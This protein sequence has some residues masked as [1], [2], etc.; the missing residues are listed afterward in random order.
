MSELPQQGDLE[1]DRYMNLSAKQENC[2][3]L[4]NASLVMSLWVFMNAPQQTCQMIRNQQQPS[5]YRMSHK[6]ESK[7]FCKTLSFQIT[8]LSLQK[9]KQ[10][11]LLFPGSLSNDNVRS[12]NNNT[13]NH[14]RRWKLKNMR[15]G[16]PARHSE[17]TSLHVWVY[18]VGPVAFPVTWSNSL[19]H[20]TDPL[21][22]W[23][24]NNTQMVFVR[25]P[26]LTLVPLIPR[27]IQ[28]IS[29]GLFEEP[30]LCEGMR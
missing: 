10:T 2:R 24:S 22:W 6:M 9:N 18:L 29:R 30:A 26:T 19:L 21:V 12:Q 1:H 15:T 7:E 5:V 20:R 14:L 27:K 25:F 16:A 17:V 23:K 4:S 13:T 11:M 3:C 8:F 28:H